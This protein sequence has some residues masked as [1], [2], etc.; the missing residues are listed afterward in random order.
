MKVTFWG[1]RG[2]I[3]VSGERF[4][5]TGGN[6][7][8][9]EVEHEGHR[10]LLDGG[11]GLRAMGAQWGWRPMKASLLFTHLHWDHIQGVPFFTP[12]FHP[13]SDLTFIG[14][15]RD[16]GGI[17]SALGLQMQP[18]QF[19][20]GLDAL[21]GA[22]RFIDQRPDR[23]FDVG[24]FKV[25]PCE[26][27]HPDGVVVYRIE[28]GGRVVVFATDIEHGGTIDAQLV[29]QSRGA[30]LLIHDAQYTAPE[31]QGVGGP[32][33]RG[34]G[35]STWNEACEVA[36]RAEVGRLALFHHDPMRGDDAVDGIEARAR[37]LFPSTLAAREGLEVAL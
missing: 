30:D 1:V 35:H 4:A 11:T 16:S 3:A 12:A 10:L 6:T 14:A 28:A 19:P 7:T 9:V 31:Y 24:P 20:I 2:S 34:W 22:R 13:D 25:T 26:Q 32:P 18:P 29:E 5:R 8:C 15:D 33:R 23:P 17:R 37:C 27:D 21:V 36:R